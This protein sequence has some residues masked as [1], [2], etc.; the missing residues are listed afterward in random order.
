MGE[1]RN[2]GEPLEW[3]PGFLPSGSMGYLVHP[4]NGM[5]GG[6]TSGSS[7]VGSSISDSALS[8]SRM[9]LFSG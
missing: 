5:G 3:I 4:T 8:T 6:S 9:I 1:R 7:P 2:D